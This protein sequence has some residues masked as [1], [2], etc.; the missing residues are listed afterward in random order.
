MVH[1]KFVVDS[2]AK[3][4]GNLLLLR[5]RVLGS[6]GP[7]WDLSI[8]RKYPVEFDEAT[9]QTDDY[10]ISLPQGY[11][12]DDIPTPVDVKSDYGSYRSKI[13]LTGSTLHYQRVYEINKVFVPPIKL[14]E[15]RDFFKEVATDERASAVL[16]KSP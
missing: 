13:E 9:V 15:A 16:R 1:Y 4:A 8:D 12:A 11:V 2:Y 5:P 7:E 6:K 3:T 10:E 14:P